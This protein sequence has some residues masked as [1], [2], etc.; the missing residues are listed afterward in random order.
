MKT[1]LTRRQYIILGS[2]LFGL[3]FGAGN[4]IF[5]IHLGQLAAGNWGPAA[6]GFLLTAILLPLLSIRNQFNS[7]A[8]VLMISHDQL[9]KGSPCSS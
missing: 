4:L 3:F 9:V 8:A 2:L 7:A 5:P 6:I 1:T